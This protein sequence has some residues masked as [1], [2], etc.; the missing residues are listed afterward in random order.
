MLLPMVG[1]LG[2]ERAPLSYAHLSQGARCWR[3]PQGPGGGGVE[4]GA[5]ALVPRGRT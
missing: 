3:G 5:E 2:P 1:T 4:G